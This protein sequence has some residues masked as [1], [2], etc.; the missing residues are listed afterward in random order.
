MSTI[1]YCPT[2]IPPATTAAGG[3]VDLSAIP[4]AVWATGSAASM[5][6]L[7]FL[8]LATD[9]MITGPA[10]RREIGVKDDEIKTLKATVEVKD[11]QLEK[12]SI[13]GDTTL[14]IL[15]SIEDM[16]KRGRS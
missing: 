9:R 3:D 1:T 13:V 4:P 15:T 7:L 10:H 16:A 11:S 2:D 12:L 8:M 14:R 6:G 5:F